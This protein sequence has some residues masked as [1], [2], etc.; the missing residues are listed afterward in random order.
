MKLTSSGLRKIIAE[1]V[2]AVTQARGDSTRSVE[3]LM[4]PDEEIA[5]A[6]KSKSR[7]PTPATPEG[8][9]EDFERGYAKRVA[10]RRWADLSGKFPKLTKRVGREAFDGEWAAREEGAAGGGGHLTYADEFRILLD[11][12]EKA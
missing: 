11:L 3:S 6:R 4:T 12:L 7:R 10:D 5:L 9:F 1:E 8:S 2:A